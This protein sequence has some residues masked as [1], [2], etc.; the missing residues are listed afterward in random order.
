LRTIVTTQPVFMAFH[1]L[2]AR[3]RDLRGRPLSERRAHLEREIDGAELVLPVRR[4]AG[5]G[6][7]AWREVQERGYEGLV[8]KDER[9]TYVGGFAERVRAGR[10]ALREVMWLEPHVVAEIRYAE[11]VQDRLRAP[12]FRGF[13]STPTL[14]TPRAAPLSKASALP[15]SRRAPGTRPART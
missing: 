9:S 1:C 11:I 4:L 2:W 3:G 10:L 5:D 8:G 15:R 13:H 6:L 14:P 12:V 7:A